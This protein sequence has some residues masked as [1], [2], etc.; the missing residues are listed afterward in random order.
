MTKYHV[1]NQ[2]GSS[3]GSSYPIV[4]M[5]TT[6]TTTKYSVAYKNVFK[7]FVVGDRR[8]TD[9][10]SYRDAVINPKRAGGETGKENERKKSLYARA[11]ISKR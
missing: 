4:K 1:K 11:L 6:T 5:Q 3:K 10:A 2:L 9:S 7:Q 8:P